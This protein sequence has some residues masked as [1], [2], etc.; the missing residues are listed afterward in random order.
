MYYY[1]DV[2]IA[3]LN[4]SIQFRLIITLNTYMSHL[5]FVFDNIAR[6]VK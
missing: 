5:L 3:S 4:T 6:R 1:D 2:M